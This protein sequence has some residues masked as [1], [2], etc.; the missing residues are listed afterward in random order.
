MSKF[1][2]S[3]HVPLVLD[4]PKAL[5]E[6][7]ENFFEGVHTVGEILRHFREEKGWSLVE[8]GEIMELDPSQIGLM[9]RGENLI[10]ERLAKRFA[11]IF[12]TSPYYFL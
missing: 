7:F 3:R 11:E 6:E 5:N 8:L 10:S 2:R 1:M 12:H 9:E 4:E